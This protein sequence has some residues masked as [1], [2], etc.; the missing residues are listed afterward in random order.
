MKDNSLILVPIFAIGF[1]QWN[2]GNPANFHTKNEGFFGKNDRYGGA[3]KSGHFYT[4]YLMSDLLAKKFT[5]DGINEDKAALYGAA[6][7]LALTTIIEIG[8]ATSKDHGFSMQDQVMNTLGAL[9]SYFLLT[10]PGL[11]KKF[12]FK[13]DYVPSNF[14]R[15]VDDYDNMR[16]IASVKLAGFDF[17]KNSWWRFLEIQA[18]YRTVGYVKREQDRKREVGIALAINIGEVIDYFTA[19][20]NSKT[21]RYSQ[22]FFEYYQPRYTYVG[23]DEN[24]NRW[25]KMEKEIC[26]GKQ[27]RDKSRP[28]NYRKYL[29]IVSHAELE[30]I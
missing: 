25:R 12:D 2:W 3:D 26:G 24:L 9:S 11:D 21:K 22:G 1:S 20:S 17:S 16:Y 30:N 14:D 4:S 27:G 18:N 15:I 28:Y 8:D 10:N 19:G 13:I 5:A 7:S 23:Y 29:E 6:S